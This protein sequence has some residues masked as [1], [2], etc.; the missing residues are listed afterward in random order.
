MSLIGLAAISRKKVAHWLS[1]VISQLLVGARRNAAP[2]GEGRKTAKP[3]QQTAGDRGAGTAPLGTLAHGRLFQPGKSVGNVYYGA[4]S[5]TDRTLVE[6]GTFCPATA[7]TAADRLA[8]YA[9]VFPIVEVD[10]TDY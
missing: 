9:G 6:G 10:A 3:R 1:P 4:C 8:F 7:T 5:W 2:S